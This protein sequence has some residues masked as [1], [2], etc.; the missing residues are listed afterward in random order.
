M[1]KKKEM[2][3]VGE[4]ILQIEVLRFQILEVLI[5]NGN[6]MI[7]NVTELDNGKI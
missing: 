4:T 7:D 2:I 6:K 3:F 5:L 1:I